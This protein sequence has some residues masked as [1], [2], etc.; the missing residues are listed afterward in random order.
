[1]TERKMGSE[2]GEHADSHRGS[3]ALGDGSR[4]RF[5]CGPR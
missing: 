5:P 3:D 2:M 4:H 1:M